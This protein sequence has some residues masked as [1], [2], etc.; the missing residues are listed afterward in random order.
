MA[1]RDNDTYRDWISIGADYCTAHH[2]IREADMSECDMS[3]P[4]GPICVLTPLC[5]PRSP[6]LIGSI[7]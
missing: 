6:V 2:G 7:P 3:E 1:A 4:V 5:I